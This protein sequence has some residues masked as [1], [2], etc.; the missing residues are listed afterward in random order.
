MAVAVLAI[1]IV[2]T[3]AILAQGTDTNGAGSFVSRVATILGLDEA[4]VRMPWI[5]L[6]ER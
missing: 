1:G 4:Q 2:A 6:A 3:G 5:R